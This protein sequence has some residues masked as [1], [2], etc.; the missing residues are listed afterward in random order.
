MNILFI[1]DALLPSRGGVERVTHTLFGVFEQLGHEVFI[2]YHQCDC[3]EVPACKKLRLPKSQEKD[4][5]Y[6]TI[7]KYIVERAI[8][9]VIVQSYYD[10]TYQV[11]YGKLKADI[12]GLRMIACLH[13]NP[14]IWVNKNRWGCTFVDIYLKELLRSVFLS[15]IRNKWKEQITGMYKIVDKFVLLSPHFIDDFKRLYRVDG[16]KLCSIPNPCAFSDDNVVAFS[17]K[18]NMVLVVARMAEQQKRISS[19]L[20]I[21]KQVYGRHPDWKLVLVGDGPD[22]NRYKCLAK[23]LELMNYEFVGASSCPQ[24]YYKRAKIF[25]MTSIWEGFCMTLIEAQHYGCVPMAYDS[26]SAIKDI[27]ENGVT[28]YII[29]LHDRNGYA[30]RLSDLMS[31]DTKVGEMSR[32]ALLASNLKFNIGNIAA[33]WNSLFRSLV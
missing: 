33:Q 29:P 31:D 26:F 13:C 9:M 8:Q 28:G 2:A 19:V 24:D 7:S 25:L 32:N 11:V 17:A 5:L 30:K 12:S 4:I 14:D 18:E 6:M 22:W 23:K 27:I 1:E 15:C 10:K 16:K 21:W 20:W 3:A